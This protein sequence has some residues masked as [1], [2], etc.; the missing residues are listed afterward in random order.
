MPNDFDIWCGNH[1]IVAPQIKDKRVRV[2]YISGSRRPIYDCKCAQRRFNCRQ[3]RA[4]LD[5][6]RFLGS[7]ADGRDGLTDPVCVALKRETDN[8][9]CVVPRDSGEVE[10]D[11][12]LHDHGSETHVLVVSGH[13]RRNRLFL[14][15]EL[16]PANVPN[17]NVVR[18]TIGK[19]PRRRI[20]RRRGLPALLR[21]R[22]P[23]RSLVTELS[24]PRTRRGTKMWGTPD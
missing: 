6:G 4:D 2:R 8:V 1:F 22:V 14:F 20:A 17:P 11:S 13:R 24:P 16:P 3:S 19:M 5:I 7:L 21:L 23:W 15:H 18:I 10:F 12:L 9:V